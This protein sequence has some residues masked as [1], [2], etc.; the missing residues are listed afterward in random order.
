MRILVLGAGGVGG[1]F[2]GRLAEKGAEVTFLVR[3]GRKQ[4][5][6]KDGLVIRSVNG[7]VTLRP[8]TITASD[9]ANP[10]DLVLFSTKAYHLQS[11]VQDLKPFVG[12]QTVILPLLN[13][14]AHL[15]L[16]KK[17]F[18][19]DRVIGGLCFI[20]ATLN[21]E[22]HVLQTSKDHYV[23]F[24]EFEGKD[25]E[26]IAEIESLL[27]GT[28]T[29]FIRSAH[30]ERDI[31][32][33]YLFIS[34]IAGVTTLMQAPIGPIRESEG[35][36]SFIRDVFSETEAVMIA[37]GAPLA[38]DIVNKHMETM[39]NLSYDM[40]SSMQRDME[41]GFAVEGEHLHGYLL[42]MAKEHSLE[43]PLIR[44]IY[45]NLQVYGVNG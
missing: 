14:V 25:T 8:N 40:K 38:Q 34:T 18:G 11:A 13:G 7:D 28:K 31:W 5:L 30:I 15:P 17:E 42:Q 26:R 6:D 21:Q 29:S 39:W 16:L 27:S 3:S 20:E 35:G 9:P 24:G 23:K 41:K 43:T 36:E 44:A 1:Y 37:H 10:Y 22:G 32:H 4:Q 33:K 45:Q 2:G 12:E 19:E